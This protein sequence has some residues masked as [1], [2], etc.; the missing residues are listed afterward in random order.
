[1]RFSC[2][3]VFWL[4][5]LHS[6][7]D[8]CHFVDVICKSYKPSWAWAR[9]DTDVRGVR[10]I[11]IACTSQVVSRCCP[12]MS[13]LA[14]MTAAGQRVTIR[15]TRSGNLERAAKM[16]RLGEKPR[17]RKLIKLKQMGKGCRYMIARQGGGRPIHSAGMR[18]QL[19]GFVAQ[20]EVW[21]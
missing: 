5:S 14:G 8:T 7:V 1:M 3:T 19:S 2:Q 15:S 20:V 6:N 18:W 16:D 11:E 10:S 13:R 12:A 17:F 9:T 21:R 4:K